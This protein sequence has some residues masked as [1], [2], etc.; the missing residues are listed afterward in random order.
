MKV[1]LLS[2]TD[3]PEKK[4]A[5]AARLCYSPIG[6]DKL[7][8]DMDDGRTQEFLSK[9]ISMGHL[10]PLE[11]ISFTFAIEGVSRVLSHQM[12]RHRIASYS[13][14]S[15]RY[16]SEQDFQYIVPPAIKENEQA[17]VLYREQMSV[18]A[19]AYAELAKIVAKED[20]RY[21]LPSACETKFVAT[22]NARSLLNF[23]Q[24]RCCRRAQWEIRQ[25]A[26]E[27]L[28][29]VR[30]VAPVIFQKAGAACVSQGVCYEGAMSC[31]RIKNVVTRG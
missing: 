18:I 17:L 13:Q 27:M 5:A 8:E 15:Q 19:D 20:A 3:Q 12:V 6:A 16:V 24:H 23:F 10:S 26:D 4:V 22:F 11:H 25:L 30:Q 31:G 1:S 29:Q 2:Y 21:I 28:S 14:K 7:L 9:L